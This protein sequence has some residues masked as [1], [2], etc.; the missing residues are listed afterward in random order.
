MTA[1]EENT[2]PGRGDGAERD[3]DAAGQT[4]KA[5]AFLTTVA[6]A[7]MVA[8]FGS[9]LAL[10]KRKSPD[11]FHKGSAPTAAA[12]RAEPAWP[13]GLWAGGPCSLGVESVCSASPC[14]RFS[15]F[16]V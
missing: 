11:W 2:A 16:T 1:A 8:G 10:A 12:R 13:S 3:E 5:A 6:S 15:V 4:L 14:G 7:G 9:T